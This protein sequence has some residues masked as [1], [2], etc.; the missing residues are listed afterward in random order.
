[1]LCLTEQKGCLGKGVTQW[2]VRARGGGVTGRA[3]SGDELAQVCRAFSAATREETAA[4]LVVVAA[5]R[6]GVEKG[7]GAVERGLL[8]VGAQ[9]GEHLEVR[10]VREAMLIGS[11]FGESGAR[12]AETAGE[13]SVPAEG[14]GAGGSAWCSVLEEERTGAGKNPRRKSATP[15]TW[16]TTQQAAKVPEPSRIV[17][18]RRTRIPGP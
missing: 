12:G 17:P 9:Q 18:N 7:A 8:G 5:T 10:E 11:S 15:S 6:C 13:G 3:T 16:I 2:T 4:W 1:M 14:S